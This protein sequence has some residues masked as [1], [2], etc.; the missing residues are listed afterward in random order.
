MAVSRLNRGRLSSKG[1]ERLDSILK[2]L[3]ATG[4][5]ESDIDKVTPG[6]SAA[7]FTKSR[8]D[9]LSSF[10][11]IVSLVVLTIVMFG[12]M[13]ILLS[14]TV[15][16]LESRRK[17]LVF[18]LCIAGLL[19]LLFFVVQQLLRDLPRVLT[20]VSREPLIIIR[21][22]YYFTFIFGVIGAIYYGGHEI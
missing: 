6:I 9:V 12:P 7:I 21:T 22:I 2:E 1:E 11:Y 10:V 16:Y 13:L 18:I 14:N 4:A 8:V 20:N 3:K 17:M 5:S 19:I 15:H